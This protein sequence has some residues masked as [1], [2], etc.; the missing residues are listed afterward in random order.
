MYTKFD[1]RGDRRECGKNIPH[2]PHI[3][4]KGYPTPMGGMETYCPGVAGDGVE[5]VVE[6]EQKGSAN[7]PSR[8][9]GLVQVQ[10]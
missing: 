10:Q 8:Y 6:F 9:I 1:F 5:V 3:S 2:A 7:W 4:G